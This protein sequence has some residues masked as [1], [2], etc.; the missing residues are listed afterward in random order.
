MRF[1]LMIILVVFALPA[2]AQQERECRG[3]KPF[4]L[5]N[6]AYGCLLDLGT[7]QITTTL[8]RDDGASSSSRRNQAG[9]IRVLVF[10][11]YNGSRQ[12][13]GARIKAICNTFLPDLKAA[14]P[15]VRYHRVVVAMIWPR[16]ANPGDFVPVSRS[17]VAVQPGF[18]SASCRGVKFFGR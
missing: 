18:S 1:V 10:G 12:V 11:E 6:G 5:G 15:D 2:A 17:K 8:T 14:I 13:A 16:V 7:T 9:H 3:K 4:D